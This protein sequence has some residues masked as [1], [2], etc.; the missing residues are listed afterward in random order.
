[1]LEI[2]KIYLDDYL[3]ITKNFAEKSIDCIIVDPP[4]GINYQSKWRTNKSMWKD[5]ILNDELP[6]IAWTDEAF[7]IMKDNTGLLCFTRYD[8]EHYFR[9]ALADSGFACKQQI[10]WDKEIH[11]MGDLKGDFASQHENIIFATKGRFI[12]KNKRPK[13]I[14]RCQKVIAT[15]LK[16]PCEKPVYLLETLIKAISSENCIVL[17]MFAGSG[18]LA[19][20][21]INTKRNYIL[22]EKEQKY[23]DICVNR[24]NNHKEILSSQFFK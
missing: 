20:A 16:H 17:D 10:I 23:Y 6:F 19:I 12:F 21:C 9:K 5:K 11:G 22:C 18:T 14:I 15:K 4:Y 1:M 8:V 24:I 13:S 7:R 2:N 3:N